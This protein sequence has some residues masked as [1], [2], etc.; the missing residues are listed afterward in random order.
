[1]AGLWTRFLLIRAV[2]V[3]LFM[4]AAVM[5]A[6]PVWTQSSA[7]AS[8]ASAFALQAHGTWI[9]THH[10]ESAL[11]QA[12]IFVAFWAYSAYARR[13]PAR[14]ADASGGEQELRPWLLLGLLGFANGILS[15]TGT[16]PG[17]AVRSLFLDALLGIPLGLLFLAARTLW[18]ESI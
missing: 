5:V 13:R 10:A 4:A 2:R 6:S 8:L 15:F 3:A 12:A 9:F 16:T 1:M 18:K 7:L 14:V 11:G 17:Q